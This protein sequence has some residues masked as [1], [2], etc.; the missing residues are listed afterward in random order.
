MDENLTLQNNE[1]DQSY[2]LILKKKH[3]QGQAGS[4]KK[5]P[6]NGSLLKEKKQ[7]LLKFAMPNLG[8]K[9]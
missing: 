4:Q 3:V 9:Y 6:N 8:Y 5:S 1:A 2:W 7:Q